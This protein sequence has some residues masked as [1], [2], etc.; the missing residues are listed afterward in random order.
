MLG[1]KLMGSSASAPIYVDDVFSAYLY[2]GNNSIQT[3]THGVDLATYG[4]M[5][6]IKARGAAGNT[7]H[8]LWDSKRNG[9]DAQAFG[10][11]LATDTTA[12]QVLYYTAN[13]PALSANQFNVPSW[14]ST[15]N[16]V[17][18]S[19]SFRKAPKFFDVVTWTGD[20]ATSRVIP[21]SLG[22]AI[23]MLI[24]KCTS[25]TGD[26]SVLLRNSNGNYAYYGGNSAGTG[27]GL[28]HNN[29]ASSPDVA[30]T[31]LTSSEFNVGTSYING[32][33]N[34]SGRTYV[35]YLFAH[36]TSTNG[37]IQCGSVT[38][39]ES[40]NASVATLGW[41]PQFLL[42]KASSIV[43]DWIMLDT[44]RGW[45]MSAK[46]GTLLA[47]SSATET[48]ATERGYPTATG[49]VFKG[50]AV[51]VTYNYLA[52]RRPNKPV[53]S[54]GQVFNLA[55]SAT[56]LRVMPGSANRYVDMVLGRADR[57]NAY[58]PAWQIVDR[59]RG[60]A[61]VS[62]A[63]PMLDTT[64]TAAESMPAAFPYLDGYSCNFVAFQAQA[65]S[66]ILYGLSRAP[67]VFD[68][69]CDTG[70]G[71]AHAI[72]HNLAAAPELWLRKCRSGV[73]AWVFGSSL[74]ANTEKI[75]CPSP[76]GKV[77]DATAWNSTTP[78]STSLTVGTLAD[79]NTIAATY[80]T[81]LWAT[82]A[83]VSKVGSYTG[84]GASQTIACG[85]AAGARFVM[86]IRTTASTAQDIFVWDSARGIVA[87]NDPHL[88]L[89]TTAAEVTTDDSID[90]NSS[91]F[92]VNQVAATNINVS[93]AIYIYLAYA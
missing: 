10:A 48:T 93:G 41:E 79:V 46:D 13:K 60:M 15:E 29:A 18:V 64:T 56:I 69:V 72:S 27:Q 8:A 45:D 91:G 38:T 92:V 78:T 21:H 12:A 39:D 81:Y 49:F 77:A 25:A 28:N 20:G 51:A 76:A 57:T 11:Y 37:L 43:S 36:D 44:Q 80:V 88:S 14:L 54:G 53:T 62:G 7:G 59:L 82:L 89:N 58:T 68:M 40:G 55:A 84:N 26:W 65:T 5:Y 50:G 33:A 63:L 4:G 35:A 6:W 52:I 67:G 16:A 34:A 90:P 24:I 9:N 85:F 1:K 61:P 17:Y 3:Y 22:S 75:V 66:S 23:G 30:Q 19:Y 42:F 31:H 73:A 87:A 32:D 47:N 74:L 2:M 83:G 86:I 70:T 71:V